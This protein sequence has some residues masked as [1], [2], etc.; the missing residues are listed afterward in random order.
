MKKIRTIIIPVCLAIALLCLWQVSYVQSVMSQLVGIEVNSNSRYVSVLDAARSGN[1]QIGMGALPAVSYIHNGTNADIATVGSEFY[2][3]KNTGVGASSVNFAFG[4]PS[5][6][7][8]IE[9]PTA[10]TDEICI[11]WDGGTAACPAANTAGDDRVAAGRITI[12]DDF[13][14]TSIS[15]IA[16]SGTQTIHVR[17]WR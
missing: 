9:T 3:I 10:N 15:V 13:V 12:L 14:G 5:K 6:K 1:N 7:I 16:A 4:F 17:A 2:A 11:D 8:M